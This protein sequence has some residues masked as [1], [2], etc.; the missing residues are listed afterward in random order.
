MRNVGL[1]TA[2]AIPPHRIRRGRYAEIARF[3]RDIAQHGIREMAFR[4]TAVKLWPLRLFR[5]RYMKYA[6]LFTAN[7]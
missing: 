3:A 7:A 4:P 5:S 2:V 1:A 6:F